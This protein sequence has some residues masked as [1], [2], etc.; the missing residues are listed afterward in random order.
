MPIT[1]F[2]NLFPRATMEKL[3]K[4]KDISVISDIY[5]K[6]SMPQLGVYIIT[7]K[8]KDKQGLYILFLVLGNN[9]ALLG[10]AGIEL[11]DIIHVKCSIKDM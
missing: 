11:L 6:T 4:H 5:N 10:I 8:H 2:K 3:L 7:I 1:I 9:P